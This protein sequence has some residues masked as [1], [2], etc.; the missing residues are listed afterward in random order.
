MD[1]EQVMFDHLTTSLSAHIAGRFYYDYAPQEIEMPYVVA[2]NISDV[3]MHTHDGQLRLETPV[4]QFTVY[5]ETRAEA[6]T[7]AE[8][9]KAAML[10]FT[11]NARLINELRTTETVDTNQIR[12]VDL[13]YEILYERGD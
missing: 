13:E 7:V 11:Y 9:V 1:L 12:T 4:Y 3:K 10:G 5:S 8:A 6:K 2:I